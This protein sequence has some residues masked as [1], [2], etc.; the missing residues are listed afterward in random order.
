MKTGDRVRD[1]YTG[2]LGT[3]LGYDEQAYRLTVVF[4]GMPGR[5]GFTMTGCPSW[6]SIL[7]DEREQA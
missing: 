1:N 5:P 3:V 7:E 4:E 2:R 6:F